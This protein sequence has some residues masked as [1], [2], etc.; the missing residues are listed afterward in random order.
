MP[1]TYLLARDHLQQAA[2][3]LRRGD[4]RSRQLLTIVERTISL[5]DD[6]PPLRAEAR[7]NVLD[8]AAFKARHLPHY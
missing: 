6:M 5:I 1:T 7:P 3:I 4:S 8:F 2:A